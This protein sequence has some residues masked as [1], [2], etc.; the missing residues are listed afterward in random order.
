MSSYSRFFII[1]TIA[2]LSPAYAWS[3]CI[4]PE[5]ESNS[6]IVINLPA[7][8]HVNGDSQSGDLLWDSGWIRG[9]AQK[10]NCSTSGD[11]YLGYARS[12]LRGG[13]NDNEVKTGIPGISMQVHYRNNA[14]GGRSM[15]LPTTGL[16]LEHPQGTIT[17]N[18]EFR[19]MLLR[20]G[21]ITSGK[22]HFYGPVLTHRL[23]H[24]RI[25]QLSFMNTQLRVVSVGCDLEDNHILVSL[26]KHDRSEFTN[27][28]GSVTTSKHFSIPLR[29]EP[30][31]TIS[32]TMESANK[33]YFPGVVEL[34][35]MSG[36][37]AG[38]GVQL[39][40]WNGKPVIFG[41]KMDVISMSQNK[42]LI[43][44]FLARYYRTSKDITPGIANSTATF[45]LTYR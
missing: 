33:S 3:E 4:F 19:V 26:G 44:D 11:E 14:S 20:R 10:I 16:R 35:K 36:A 42:Y 30:G 12:F 13:V 8:L 5:N 2:L 21:I 32:L 37:A 24:K 22:S 38:V 15:I 29:C 25:N 28:I 39:L 34:D 45:T 6:D 43:I 27:D 41:E 17:V 18:G 31:T 23:G 40:K 1:L 7:E 9:T